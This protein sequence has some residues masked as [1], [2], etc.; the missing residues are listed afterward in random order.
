MALLSQMFQQNAMQNPFAQYAQMQANPFT[1]Q[2]P[3]MG[4]LPPLPPQQAPRMPML[5]QGMGE[6]GNMPLPPDF[7]GQT[8]TFPNIKDDLQGFGFGAFAPKVNQNGSFRQNLIQQL[9][10]QMSM[11][12]MPGGF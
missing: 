12:G 9:L 6:I 8:Q 2:L 10:S 7:A 11:Q 4:Y 3:G 1:R 5:N